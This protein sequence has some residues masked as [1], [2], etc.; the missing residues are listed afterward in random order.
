MRHFIS[1]PISAKARGTD[2]QRTTHLMLTRG[3]L[4][5]RS[6]IEV[7]TQ[8]PQQARR[9]LSQMLARIRRAESIDRAWL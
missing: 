5:T 3:L 1:L 6:E 7:E 8:S 4:A 9:N 2:K